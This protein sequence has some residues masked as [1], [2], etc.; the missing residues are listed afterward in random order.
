MIDGERKFKNYQVAVWN[1]V[2]D[3]T[4]ERIWQELERLEETMATPISNALPQLE[5]EREQ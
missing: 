4:R 2:D 3:E 1:I 5:I